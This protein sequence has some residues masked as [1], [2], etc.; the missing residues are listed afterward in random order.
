MLI[1][2]KP[3]VV[4]RSH[5]KDYEKLYK[6]SI[7]D[8]ELFWG[9]I[10]KELSWYKPWEKVLDWKFPYARW[11]VGGQTNI[12]SNALDRWMNSDVKNKTAL[13]W[14]SQKQRENLLTVS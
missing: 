8:P 13:I 4:G 2:P 1:N 11:F 3:E 6:E 9:N 12:I 5:V 14:V 7:V 10:A